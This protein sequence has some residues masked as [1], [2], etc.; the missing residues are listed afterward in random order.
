MAGGIKGNLKKAKQ[1]IK[2]QKAPTPAEAIKR[3]KMDI[4][5]LESGEKIEQR[6]YKRLLAEYESLEARGKSREAESVLDKIVSKEGIIKSMSY[7]MVVRNNYINKLEKCESM[8]EFARMN[9]DLL[10]MMEGLEMQGISA[11]QIE[12][13]AIEMQSAMDS[14]SNMAETME[15][16]MEAA[17][18]DEAVNDQRKDAIRAETRAKIRMASGSIASEQTQNI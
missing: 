17:Y 9:K 18:V 13:D 5:K 15:S 7:Q 14:L 12:T 6:E 8:G 1:A 4:R 10:G 2:G 11:E 3:C 16:S